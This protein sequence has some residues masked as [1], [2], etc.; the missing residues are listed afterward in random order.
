MK[1]SFLLLFLISPVY[2]VADTQLYLSCISQSQIPILDGEKLWI[3]IDKNN[4]TFNEIT[5][6]AIK[7]NESYNAG[8]IFDLKETSEFYNSLNRTTLI[9]TRGLFQYQ[10]RITSRE[11]VLVETKKFLS[12]FLIN[13]KL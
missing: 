11:V 13:R 8:R 1:K 7:K 5:E 10:C 9:Y 6:D 4:N 3:Y 2:L 12:N